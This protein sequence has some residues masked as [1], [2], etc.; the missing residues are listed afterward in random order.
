VRKREPL[1]YKAVLPDGA[2]PWHAFD[3]TNNVLVAVFRRMPNVKSGNYQNVVDVI[4]DLVVIRWNADDGKLSLYASDY[5]AMRSETMAALVTD[6]HTVPVSGR[7]IFRILN[8]V[9]LPLAKSLGS[10]PI[11]VRDAM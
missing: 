6:E 3:E 9:E 10:G 1:A 8:N 4:H 5:S 2:E 11:D 7:S